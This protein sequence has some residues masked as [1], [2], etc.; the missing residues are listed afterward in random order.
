MGVG[1]RFYLFGLEGKQWQNTEPHPQTN[2]TLTADMLRSLQTYLSYQYL[3]AYYLS[4]AWGNL[5]AFRKHALDRRFTQPKPPNQF[6]WGIY[7]L[8]ALVRDAWRNNAQYK[9]YVA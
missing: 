8:E 2:N 4:V 1:P 6:S 9:V 3:R 7:S 5:C